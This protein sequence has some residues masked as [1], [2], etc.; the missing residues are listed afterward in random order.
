MSSDDLFGGL[1]GDMGRFMPSM[2]ADIMKMMRV[3][4]PA[5]TEL[6]TQLALSVVAD[7]DEANV[8][9]RD[10]ITTEQLTR[11]AELHVADVTGMSTSPSGHSIDVQ[12]MTRTAWVQRS[13]TRWRDILEQI[14]RARSLTESTPPGENL[15]DSEPQD[16]AVMMQQ[17]FTM[18]APTLAAMQIG[19]IIGHLG[20]RS[21]GQYDLL[22]PGDFSDGPGVVY[23]NRKAFANDWSLPEEDAMLWMSV[24]DISLHSVLS[25]AHVAKRLHDLV[26]AHAGTLNIDS[27][28]LQARLEASAPSSM[29]ELADLLGETGAIG[30]AVVSPEDQRLSRE[31]E[32]LVTLV[33]GYADWVA[34]TVAERAIGTRSVIIEAI[35]RSRIDRSED[36][37]AA[38]SIIGV[39]QNFEMFE[40]GRRFV[41]GII[42]RN[43]EQSLAHLWVVEKNLPTPAELDAPGLWLERIHL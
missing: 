27:N 30:A 37:T 4:N 3:Q 12:T 14:V 11:I 43:G 39:D 28:A 7:P 19:S 5:Q 25:R 34:R 24:Y 17:W 2:F 26:L 20:K 18:L 35:T 29:T 9:P 38:D 32:T 21:L 13:L 16:V 10:R 42:D 31:R 6:I 8:D 23:K 40:R 33:H 36:E 1:G 41:Q 15:D 22:L